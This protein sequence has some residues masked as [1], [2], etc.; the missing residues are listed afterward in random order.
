MIPKSDRKRLTPKTLGDLRRISRML[1]TDW[2]LQL[3]EL[4]RHVGE[5]GF[6]IGRDDAS[7]GAGD[8]VELKLA[9]IVI[10]AAFLADS[11]GIDLEAL[12]PEILYERIIDTVDTRDEAMSIIEG[13]S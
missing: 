13:K 7:G 4:T 12:L 6:H 8:D 11:R 9:N 2:R 3:A 1:G 10:D 5:L